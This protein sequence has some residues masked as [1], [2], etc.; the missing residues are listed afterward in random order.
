[1]RI[2]LI[3]PIVFL[4]LDSFAL[5]RFPQRSIVIWRLI[6]S[7]R[8]LFLRC[9]LLGSQAHPL[10]SFYF[11]RQKLMTLGWFIR[12]CSGILLSK[13][14]KTTESSNRTTKAASG[15]ASG[16]TIVLRFTQRRA[17]RERSDAER[18][19]RESYRWPRCLIGDYGSRGGR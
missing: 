9:R 2:S 1:M 10:S 19:G 6:G 15:E 3:V 16:L 17:R 4:S 14:S 5:F 8:L 11:M 12:R 13:A 7:G 18:L